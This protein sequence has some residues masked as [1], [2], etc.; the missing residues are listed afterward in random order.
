MRI[1]TELRNLPYTLE[2]TLVTHYP[3]DIRS[4]QNLRTQSIIIESKTTQ[5]EMTSR[6]GLYRF[7]TSREIPLKNTD[8]SNPS[9]HTYRLRHIYTGWTTDVLLPDNQPAIADIHITYR[10]EI[11]GTVSKQSTS[12]ELEI[13]TEYPESVMNQLV[14]R[15]YT[16]HNGWNV[17]NLAQTITGMRSILTNIGIRGPDDLQTP[18]D[19]TWK[20]LTYENL[21][22]RRHAVSFKADG[23]RML[24]VKSPIG[25][26]LAT[27]IL[28]IIP[29]DESEPVTSTT[30][31]DGEFIQEENLYWCFDLLMI[32]DIN[33]MSQPYDT[34]YQQIESTMR[35]ISSS[36]TVR[37]KPIA[38]PTSAEEFFSVIKGIRDSQMKSD[39]IIF[40]GVDQSYASSV[41]KWKDPTD[42]TVDFFVNQSQ[43]INAS[44][45]T[46]ATLQK[47]SMLNHPEFKV[48][49]DLSDQIGTV[50]E[51]RYIDGILWEEVRRRDDKGR[52]NSET[53]LNVILQ[54]HRDPITWNVITGESLSLMRKYH[55]RVKRAVYDL[56]A[57]SDTVTLTDVGSGKGG[58]LQSWSRS[59]L[60]VNAI[61][62]DKRNS[63]ELLSRAEQM[64]AVIDR[65][66]SVS[67]EIQGECWSSTLFM[68]DIER[69]ISDILPSMPR[70][71][72]LTFFNSLTFLSLDTVCTLVNESVMDTGIIVMM[73]IDGSVLEREF[74]QS[75]SYESDLIQMKRVSC[76]QYDNCISIRLN[77]SS[78]VD[79]D[80][81]ENLTDV[82][83]IIS[84]MRESGWTPDIDI[85]LTQEKLLGREEMMY[86]SAQ[87]LVIFK[88]RSSPSYLIRKSYRPLHPGDISR[89]QD[90]PWGD[91]TRI[92]VIG[93]GNDSFIHAVLQS[94]DST[95]RSL[96][97]ISK[98]IYAHS[99]GKKVIL[100][101]INNG[102]S[103]YM[104]PSD[105]W[106]MYRKVSD[107]V[108]IYNPNTL[109]DPGIVIMINKRQW[110]PVGRTGLNSEIQYI[111]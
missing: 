5:K 68:M 79:R 2:S 55:N 102:I 99:K 59:H 12:I 16:L 26:F 88:R 96:D 49:S 84:M 109:R 35:D 69:Y 1:L 31:L 87:R 100:D 41:Y 80:Q 89:I 86:S 28:G 60:D 18:Y 82:Q 108:E 98:A 97:N 38:I 93:S 90:S 63:D 46:L 48:T 20:D 24:Y 43:N 34:R 105:N 78:T 32:R 103:I 110:E 57:E 111:W 23:M 17:P 67:T 25:S 83:S 58:D 61:E 11:T 81:I 39:G 74:L 76:P 27:P 65:I 53:V 92:G 4:V 64:G 22:K 14:Q 91:I 51:F 106:D 40:T 8:L 10:T 54:L 13:P 15:I 75:D 66:D 70:T 33:V 62:P 3:N 94:G 47:G 101:L 56:L 30:I 52:P 95:Y 21:I 44:S 71:D 37:L 107:S 7:V 36:M 85:Y 50:H 104:I 6:N 73:V 45:V 19:L 9:G 77:D 42:M 72:G 29:L